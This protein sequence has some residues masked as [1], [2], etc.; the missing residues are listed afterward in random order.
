MKNKNTRFSALNLAVVAMLAIFNGAEAATI[1]WTNTAGGNW[2]V[3]NNWSPN[4]VP[5]NADV[6]RITTPGTYTVTLDINTDYR[7]F[8]PTVT[9]GAGGGAAGMQTFAMTNF[10]FACTNMVVTNGGVLTANGY[11]VGYQ[12]TLTVNGGVFNALSSG[13]E[14]TLL[15]TNGGVI[16]STNSGFG[17]VVA[18]GG[19]F[20]GNGSDRLNLTVAHGGVL[21]DCAMQIPQGF[22]MTVASG[23]VLNVLGSPVPT[24]LN[25]TI[26]NYGTLN[27]TNS[28][29]L[30]G[31]GTYPTVLGGFVNQPGGVMNFSGTWDIT[32]SVGF[33]ETDQTYFT[34]RGSLTQIT[35]PT[36]VITVGS[37]ENSQG[38]VTN[39]SGVLSMGT[40]TNLSGIYY[41]AAGAT[42]QFA[43]VNDG[44]NFVIAGTPLVLAGPGQFQ[45]SSGDLYLP[46][47]VI[48]NLALLGGQ[49]KLGTS[50]QGGTITNLTL[51]GITLLS[52]S[53]PITGSFSATNNSTIEGDSVVASGGHFTA[54]NFY[55]QGS[56]RVNSGG[57]FTASELTIAAPLLVAAGGVANLAADISVSAPCTNSGTINLSNATVS[58]VNSSG[59]IFNHSGG[60]MNFLGDGSSIF[61]NN[62]PET[63]INQGSL[64]F[65]S[66]LGTNFITFLNLDLSQG[67]VTNLAGT[68]IL[69]VFQTNLAGTY[70]AAAGTTIQFKNSNVDFVNDYDFNSVT[71]FATPG[72]PFVLNGG[73]Q[74]Q[75]AGGNLYLPANVPPH[76]SLLDGVLKL[77]PNFQGGAI[78]NLTF[79]GF[80]LT[81]SL[82]TSFPITGTLTVSNCGGNDRFISYNQT[83]PTGVWGNFT[84]ASGGK[85]NVSVSDLHG[86]VTVANGGLMTVV[87]G[88]TVESDGSLTVANGGRLNISGGGLNLYSLLTNAGTINVSNPPDAFESAIFIDNDGSANYQGGLVNQATGLINLSGDYTALLSGGGGYEYL[89]NQG[90]ITKLSG[91]TNYSLLLVPFITNSGAITVQ[92]GI[93]GIRPFVTQA[94][95]SLNVVLNSATNYGSFIATGA[96]LNPLTGTQTLAGAFNATLAN[97]YL[98]TNGTGFNVL[99]YGA[100][101]GNF[102]SL[103]LPSAVSWQPTYGSTNFILVVGSPKPRFGTYNVAGTNLIFNGIGGSPGSNYIILVSTN[104]TLPLPNWSVLTTNTFDGGGQ[105]HYTNHVSPAKSR[106]F[107]IFKLP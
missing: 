45:F 98:P 76:L 87:Q 44:V 23:G 25:G 48:P 1:N 15:V 95:G 103:G 81:N 19:T 28:G 65:N 21:N 66:P 12:G 91:T 13:S 60:A 35:G 90:H 78:T 3:A 22:S 102:A 2:S 80:L 99:S 42:N 67:T 14:N 96:G 41:A 37:F 61:Y 32:A 104:L 82:A 50:F 70:Y 106:Q 97:G 93:M 17:G 30:L 6:V 10:S 49:L 71:N 62:G 31:Y 101:T 43:V 59:I 11:P 51:E 9:L 38:T 77:G 72:T 64:V 24:F 39:L 46:A 100:F 8:Y 74:F 29:F 54:V 20:N 18:N 7:S 84:V 52:N 16:N 47:N 36:G 34:N 68:T 86:A 107:F 73:G 83:L 57:T 69:R 53:L 58:V 56:I 105:F 92:S 4:Q 5:N 33:G 27:V 40:L 88:V 94:G 89:V 75:F 55:S 79:G 63:F 85:L 26:I